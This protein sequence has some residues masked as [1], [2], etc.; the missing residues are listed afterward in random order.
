MLKW[1]RFN[2]VSVTL[3]FA[4]LYLPIV[5]LVIFSFNESKLVTV[6][7]GFS[8]KWY[9][10]LMSNQA[11]LDA[12][13]VTLRVGLLSATFAT[14][15]GTMA[16]LTLVRYT[17]FRGRMLFSGMVYAP[18]VMPEVITGLSL[19]LLFVAIGLDRGFWTITLAHTTLTMCF[20]AVVVQSRLL[21][22]DHSIEEAAQDLGAPPVRTFFEITLP[23]I[24][25]AVASG[26]IL[27]FTLSLDDLVIASFTSGPGATTLPMRI[28]SQVR[29]GVTPEINAV[30]TILIGIVALGVICASI[31][32]KR[33]ET[34]RQRDERAAA[35]GA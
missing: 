16:A 18:L 34:Q 32:T 11:L 23:I 25:P 2:I 30:C 4:F 14:I 7:G 8:T 29:L 12:A 19:L 35:A 21:S 22:F 1:T 13:W 10:S 20:V 26:W 17:R 6:W 24:A 5:L 28:Y 3:G 15:L 33:R 31:I 27:A 9:V